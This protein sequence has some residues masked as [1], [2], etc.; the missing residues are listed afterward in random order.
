[1]PFVI[2]YLN[3]QRQHGFERPMQE[4]IL[5][6]A[7]LDQYRAVLPWLGIILACAVATTMTMWRGEGRAWR[8][9]AILFMVFSLLTF[10]LSLGPVA[11]A[12][13]QPLGI[14]SLYRVLY[15]WVPGF[16][17]L[18]VAS[19]YGAVMLVF[20]PVLAA[21][22]A[23][24]LMQVASRLGRAIVVA[25]GVAFLWQVWPSTFQVN[26]VLPS[27]GLQLPPAYLTPAPEL[28]PI[29][30]AVARLD[31]AAVVAEF[32]FGD[33]WYEL[34]YMFFAATHGRRLMNGYSGV[35]PA[36]YI[37]RQRRLAD[38]LASPGAAR[39]ALN[40]A[41]HVVVHERAWAD[42]TG[43]RIVAWLESLGAVVVA[44]E[45]G[46]RLLAMESLRRDARLSTPE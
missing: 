23:A 33:S 25:V 42:D 22:G 10:W 5:F 34:R 28:P 30:A 13:G 26:G 8:P 15:E 3:M 29:Y 24:S 12:G 9:Y 27:T 2:P 40:G 37:G 20:L 6:S 38:P 21:M 11:R 43:Q 31:G 44:E 1:V 32:P 16:N 35:F 17:G 46:V 41:T 7:T 39:D 18:R 4:I 36:S 14:P 45:D 19:R